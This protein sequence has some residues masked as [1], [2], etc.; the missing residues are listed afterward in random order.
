VT[1]GKLDRVVY[2]GIAS[3]CFGEPIAWPAQVRIARELGVSQP[4]VSRAIAR[5]VACGWI[6]IIERRPA[7][8]KPFTFNVYALLE[9]WKPIAGWVRDRIVERA[10][11]MRRKAVN[12][13]LKGSTAFRP[14]NVPTVPVA[15]VVASARGASP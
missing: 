12:T 14:Q 3:Y 1:L 9:A 8:A 7:R 11:A 6:E 15:P 13:N 4:T 10:R 5:L 2:Q